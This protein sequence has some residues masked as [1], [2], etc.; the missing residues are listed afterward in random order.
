M[1]GL[2]RVQLPKDMTKLA[3]S[4]TAIATARCNANPPFSQSAHHDCAFRACKWRSVKG[5]DSK[6]HL[7]KTCSDEPLEIQLSGFS[8]VFPYNNKAGRVLRRRRPWRCPA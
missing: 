5:E 6:H 1:I 3:T 8:L 2:V 4:V 7:L